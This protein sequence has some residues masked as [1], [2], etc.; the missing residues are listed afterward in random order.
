MEGGKEGWQPCAIE[1]VHDGLSGTGAGHLMQGRAQPQRRRAPR[2]QVRAT[3]SDAQTVAVPLAAAVVPSGFAFAT[4]GTI[5]VAVA[6][7]SAPALCTWMQFSELGRLTRKAKLQWDTLLQ[8]KGAEKLQPQ[9]RT[10]SP[11]TTHLHILSALKFE[12]PQFQPV[13]RAFADQILKLCS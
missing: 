10:F 11:T 7:P 8:G 9:F 4:A 3:W 2:Q 5:A 12:A 1:H 13:L 6:L